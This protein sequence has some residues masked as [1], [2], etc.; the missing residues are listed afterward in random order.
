M[1]RLL[2]TGAD[3]ITHTSPYT[4]REAIRALSVLQLARSR[5]RATLHYARN[6]GERGQEDDGHTGASMKPGEVH[7]ELCACR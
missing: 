4:S 5:N 3:N 6:P 2:L 7:H 1:A